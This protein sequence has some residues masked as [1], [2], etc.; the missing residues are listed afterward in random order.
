MPSAYESEPR[1]LALHGLRL[2]GFADAE[3]VAGCVGLDA[4]T[5]EVELKAAVD[6]GLAQYREGRLT[7][8]GLTPA[9]RAE[10]TRLLAE[11]LA[12]ASCKGTVAKGYARFLALNTQLLEACTTW[13]MRTVDGADVPNDHSDPAHDAD[14]IAR[15]QAVNREVQPVCT[16]L[17]AALHR[18]AHYGPRLAAAAAKVAAGD[19]D[20]FT[21]PMID[22][23]HT[24]W[25]ELHEDLLA[26][27]G[28]E[29][30]KE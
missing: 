28:I 20:W 17:G 4:G 23:F 9:G 25:F 3:A 18:Y 29:R 11:E 13:Q 7:G 2:K 8:Y 26:T 12:V 6:G 15:L 16:D 10:H 21:K 24:V 22:S 14:A 27:L 5:A 19:T 30:G 1:L